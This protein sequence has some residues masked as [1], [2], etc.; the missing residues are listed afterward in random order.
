MTDIGTLTEPKNKMVPFLSWETITFEFEVQK[1]D[2]LDFIIE[3][4]YLKQN[5][6]ETDSCSLALTTSTSHTQSYFK[7]DLGL[8]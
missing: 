1:N 2:S 8:K 4:L 7:I 3:T 6:F 5:L